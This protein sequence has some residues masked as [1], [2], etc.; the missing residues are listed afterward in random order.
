MEG[1]EATLAP[2]WTVSYAG[3]SETKVRKKRTGVATSFCV[4]GN[5]HK[6]AGALEEPRSAKRVSLLPVSCLAVFVDVAVVAVTRIG[7][8]T[9]VKQIPRVFVQGV[10][11]VVT[12]AAQ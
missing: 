10:Q 1:P 2:F 12:E 7:A 6:K 4:G 8:I 3:F 5:S 9:A 11:V